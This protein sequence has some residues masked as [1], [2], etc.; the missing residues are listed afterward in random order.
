[1]KYYVSINKRVR[2][3]KAYRIIKKV[4]EKTNKISKLVANL[5]DK[6]IA[7]KGLE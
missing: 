1:M 5:V 3:I 6:Y 2:N 4:N 7:K